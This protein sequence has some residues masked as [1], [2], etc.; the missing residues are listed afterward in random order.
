MHDGRPRLGKL[1]LTTLISLNTVRTGTTSSVALLRYLGS[2]ALF[3]VS[4]KFMR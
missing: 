2:Y 3:T 4:A 1:Q